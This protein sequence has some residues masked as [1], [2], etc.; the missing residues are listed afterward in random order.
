MSNDDSAL[1]ITLADDALDDDGTCPEG[2]HPRSGRAYLWGCAMR[3]SVTS[4]R[5]GVRELANLI[6]AL[7]V[8]CR[9]ESMKSRR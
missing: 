3:S 5:R 9:S 2:L 4:S 1:D 7:T 8:D 6:E